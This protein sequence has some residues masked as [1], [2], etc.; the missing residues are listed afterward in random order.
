[1]AEFRERLYR[2]AALARESLAASA[3]ENLALR[4]FTEYAKGEMEK[5]L[6]SQEAEH[7]AFTAEL[8]LSFLGLARY[9]RKHAQKQP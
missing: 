1:L 6:G 7:H 9:L 3:D 5:V 2:W 4:A 8:R